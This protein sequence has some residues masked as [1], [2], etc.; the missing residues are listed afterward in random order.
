MTRINTNT[1]SLN[2]QKT[3]KRNNADLQTSLTRLSTGLR[4]NSGKD[5]PAGLIA[6]EIMQND[7]RAT[8]QAITNTERGNQMI[9]T[10]DSALGSIG[11]LLHDIRALVTEVANTAVMDDNQIAA[12]Q[13]QVDSALEA[14][15]RIAQVTSFQ[16]R[17]LLNGGLDFITNADS[18]AQ[19][20]NMKI[21]KAN[22]GTANEMSVLVEIASA[23]EQAQITTSSGE[24]QANAEIRFA[25]RTRLSLSAD[26]AANDGNVYIQANSLSEEFHNVNVVFNNSYETGTL[27]N[28][29]T[30]YYD[31]TQ[32]ALYIN[33]ENAASTI[34][35]DNVIAAI[36]STDLFTV[37]TDSADTSDGTTSLAWGTDDNGYM[38][39][40]Y[41]TATADARGDA[42]NDVQIKFN[43]N[44]S[45][46]PGSPKAAY[47]SE[48]KTIT[49]TLAA[50]AASEVDGWNS[51]DNIAGAINDLADFS[52]NVTMT[53]NA[54][55]AADTTYVFGSFDLDTKA[56]AD[57]AATGYLKSAF[58]DATRA[59]ATVK[60]AAGVVKTFT[61]DS[62]VNT[63]N[64]YIKAAGLGDSYDQARVQFVADAS[65][66]G[67]EA[68]EWDAG[69]K[70]LSVHYFHDVTTSSSVDQIAAAINASNQWQ[71]T[72]A[73]AS[74]GTRLVDPGQ[75]TV[76]TSTDSVVV[77]ATQ[78]GANFNNMQVVFE[79]KEGQG[80]ASPK[81]KYNASTNTFTF[82]VD[83]ST[84]A[85]TRLEDLV[86][87]I[88]DVEGFG[89]YMNT[90]TNSGIGG[91]FGGGVDATIVGNTGSSGG[92]VLLDDLV[93][94]I[95]GPDG[96]EVFTFNAG[97]TANQMSSA[98]SLVA[99]A[100]GVEAT[101]NNDLVN[102]Q[103]LAYGGDSFVSVA[104][105]SEGGKGRVTKSLSASRAEGKD[106]DAK[107]NGVQATSKGNQMWVNTSTLA[108]TIDVTA[109][110]DNNFR[111][112]IDGGGAQFQLGPDV[113]SNQQ[114]R[115][116][117][118]SLNTARLGGVNGY[119]YQLNTGSSADLRTDPNQAA[120]ILENAISVVT[121][122]RGRLGALQGFTMD[123][124]I[125]TL[126][127]TMENLT[128]AESQIRDADFA[129]ETANLT[130]AQ[131]LVQSGTTVLSIANQNPQN[132]L[133]LLQ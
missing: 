56:I 29:A 93:I 13:L 94:E 128:Q 3:L 20:K 73:T 41:I 54:S 122:L 27:D 40:D 130:R 126:E 22:L 55:G 125:K 33:V 60:F 91:M 107:I 25:S 104:V 48:S 75:T 58:S 2:A 105:L 115:V 89:G 103:S 51:L 69:S 57:T 133:A 97:T 132:V 52:A 28:G 81:A 71:A 114:V 87:A 88:N 131:V 108:L 10:A 110:V 31:T 77:E 100:I 66:V 64:M 24:S 19:I 44:D 72:V 61:T 76:V 8:Q 50:N 116:G 102:I 119:L 59:Q 129:V 63:T 95:A 67:Q 26:S 36:E 113:V 79:A 39:Q 37:Y 62:G 96:A 11:D 38:T 1:S 111:F 121:D 85:P 5:D 68:V 78:A 42:W 82:M 32:K 6:A 92:N 12:N 49:V 83:Y 4:I 112:N 43:Y 90:N 46:T 109:R 53:G 124:N 98:I 118:Q 15:N 65:A 70:T 74:E 84:T 23:A 7:I 101:F 17:S 120:K 16:G 18:I 30:A 106:V 45:T 86:L 123:T 14:I 35:F 9:A 117:I 34:A 80:T 99:D 21:D 47:D 127:D